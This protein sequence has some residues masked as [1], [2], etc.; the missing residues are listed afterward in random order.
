MDQTAAEMDIKP[1]YDYT[2][3][4]KHRPE[5][6]GAVKDY[7]TPGKPTTVHIVPHSHDDVGWLKTVDQYFYGSK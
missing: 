1:G 3:I 2:K 6:M 7:K 5:V 4:H